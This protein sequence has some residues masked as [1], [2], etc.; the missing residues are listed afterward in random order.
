MIGDTFLSE[1]I[2]GSLGGLHQALQALSGLCLPRLLQ[3]AG[4]GA[5]LPGS[6]SV[7]F[8]LLFRNPRRHL[9]LA[10]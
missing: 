3:G 1:A 4:R 8:L 5:V 7:W 9:T 2:L 6:P 10:L